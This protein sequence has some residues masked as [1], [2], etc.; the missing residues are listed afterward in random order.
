MS[1]CTIIVKVRPRKSSI[2]GSSTSSKTTNKR[3]T[4]K[5]QKKRS[6]SDP[7]TTKH[8]STQ[9]SMNENK[10]NPTIITAESLSETAEC[11]TTEAP[12]NLSVD[13]HE[14]QPIESIST[15]TMAHHSN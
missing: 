11:K 4:V 9:L 1:L 7:D 3:S 5:I 6:S 10:G 15:V 14:E 13:C 2:L 12:C 8:A